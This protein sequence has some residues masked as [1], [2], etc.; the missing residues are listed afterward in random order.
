MTFAEIIRNAGFTSDFFPK[1]SQIPI[2]LYDRKDRVMTE[3]N[4]RF[5]EPLFADNPNSMQKFYTFLK[6][7]EEENIQD[8][9]VKIDEHLVCVFYKSPRAIIFLRCC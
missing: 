4:L 8:M 9:K 6:G 5:A 3:E 2:T 1:A 7:L